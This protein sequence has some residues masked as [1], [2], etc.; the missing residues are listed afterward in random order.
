MKQTLCRQIHYL[1][2]RSYKRYKEERCPGRATRLTAFSNFLGR[3]VGSSTHISVADSPNP[4]KA[5]RIIMAAPAMSTIVSEDSREPLRQRND[6]ESC[7][8]DL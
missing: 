7:I 5:A 8:D 2:K 1:L 4:Q 3:S 6:R